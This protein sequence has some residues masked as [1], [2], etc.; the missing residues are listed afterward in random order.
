MSPARA[1][2][3]TRRGLKEI[4]RIGRRWTQISAKNA[5]SAGRV[6]PA[7]QQEKTRICANRLESSRIQFPLC[8]L[9]L[10]VLS[11]RNQRRERRDTEQTRFAQAQPKTIAT[12]GNR[13]TQMKKSSGSSLICVH[14]SFICGKNACQENKIMGTCYTDSTE[15]KLERRNLLAAGRS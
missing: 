15:R 12:D 11:A 6:V 1:A 9:C 10:S 13:W 7:T 14:R 2:P 4:T 5:K 8:A 3:A